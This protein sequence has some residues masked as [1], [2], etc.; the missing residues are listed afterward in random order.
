MNIHTQSLDFPRSSK[1]SLRFNVSVRFRTKERGTIVKL[2]VK[3][4]ATKTAGRRGEERMETACPFFPSPLSVFALVPFFARPKPE[5]PFLGLSL[6]RN[7]KTLAA[8]ADAGYNVSCFHRLLRAKIK[9]EGG[10]RLKVRLRVRVRIRVRERE[11]A[12]GKIRKIGWS[13]FNIVSVRLSCRQP[14]FPGLLRQCISVTYPKRTK[15]LARKHDPERIGR[16]Q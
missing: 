10:V 2:C 7:Q 6:L 4:G 9:G 12:K 14:V 13:D 15:N 1:R 8:Q 16:A 11:K 5:I 3:N